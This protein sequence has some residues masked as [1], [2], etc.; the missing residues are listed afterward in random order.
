MAT[1][2]HRTPRPGQA[3]ARPGHAKDPAWAGLAPEPAQAGPAHEPAWGSRDGDPAQAG[4]PRGRRARRSARASRTRGPVWRALLEAQWR[5]QL[6]QVTE[7]SL[8]YHEAA[9]AAAAPAGAAPAGGPGERKVRKLLRRTVAAR[10]ALADTEEA[11]NRLAS[12][13]YGRC[14]GCTAAIPARLLAAAPDSRY[15]PRCRPRPG[16][17]SGPVLAARPALNGG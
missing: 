2:E 17:A 13:R 10:R 7:L 8:A 16:R 5:D 11:L 12:G 6:Q 15:C 1:K 14:E 3:P 4:R 9:S